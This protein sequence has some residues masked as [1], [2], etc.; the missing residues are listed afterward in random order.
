MVFGGFCFK[1][2]LLYSGFCDTIYGE[3]Y[4]W[5]IQWIWV[6]VGIW[7]PHKGQMQ[8]IVPKC[9][10]TH[11]FSG[12][13]S[14]FDPHCV[15]VV[16]LAVSDKHILCN[17]SLDR[18]HCHIGDDVSGCEHAGFIESW[19]PAK[20]PGSIPLDIP[21]ACREHSVRHPRGKR[22]KRTAEIIYGI[23]KTI[24]KTK[25]TKKT[26]ISEPMGS[27]NHREYQ[28]NKKTKIS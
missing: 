14:K 22:K 25:K 8:P 13:F 21:R 10:Q 24:E 3:I 5:R 17:I 12:T 19:H 6:Q 16:R 28:Q 1:Q 23:A 11:T 18:T 4:T 27:Q 20:H 9:C 15:Y 7:Q 2:I 26:K